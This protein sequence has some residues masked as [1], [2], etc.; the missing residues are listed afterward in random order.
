M[1]FLCFDI[2]LVILYPSGCEFFFLHCAV[3]VDVLVYCVLIYTL[4]SPFFIRIL[5]L[6]LN[7]RKRPLYD[8]GRT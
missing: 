5:Y 3:E 1:I 4:N 2:I 6:M 8:L 7:T